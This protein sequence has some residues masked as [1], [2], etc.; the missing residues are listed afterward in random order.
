MSLF[1]LYSKGGKSGNKGR[2][3]C[4]AVGSQVTLHYAMRPL[5]HTL[6]AIHPVT[7]FTTS[8]G[9]DKDFVNNNRVY[10]GVMVLGFVRLLLMNINISTV[11]CWSLVGSYYI[12]FNLWQGALATS[13]SVGSLVN[14]SVS[15]S[16]SSLVS[17]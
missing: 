11:F 12:Y 4:R 6:C 7:L 5:P 2:V 3:I 10:L 13:S 8:T 15:S 1:C 14:S 9:T 17:S 16:V